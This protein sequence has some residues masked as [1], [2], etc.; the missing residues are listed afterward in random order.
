LAVNK[1]AGRPRSQQAVEQF[2]FDFNAPAQGAREVIAP[3]SAL[4]DRVRSAALD[5]QLQ[6]QAYVLAVCELV[7]S[8]M[9]GSSIIST[10]HFLE[11]N[12]EF[13][14]T[15]EMLS[16]EA[17]RRAIDDAMTRIV[18]SREPGEF[19][20]H[21]ATHCRLCNFLNICSAGREHV[22]SMR[23]SSGNVVN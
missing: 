18:S 9:A 5:Y 11:P 13:H 6:M 1:R 12:V 4:D 8:L 2:A 7:P 22:R 10:L 17:C 14:L 21:T 23:Q 15:A 3:E 20:V 19:P 16:P